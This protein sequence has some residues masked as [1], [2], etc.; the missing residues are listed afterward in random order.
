[1]PELGKYATAVFSAWGLSL[2]ALAVL[3]GLSWVQSRRARRNLEAA[4]A[5]LRSRKEAPNGRD[6]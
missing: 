3:I 5:R 1:M 6:D 4:E 2:A